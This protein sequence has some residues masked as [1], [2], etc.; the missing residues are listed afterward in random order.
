[1]ISHSDLPLHNTML[2]NDNDNDIFGES[3]HKMSTLPYGL[4]WGGRDLRK[5]GCHTVEG[6]HNA[7]TVRSVPVKRQ[8]STRTFLKRRYTLIL[9]LLVKSTDHNMGS[10]NTCENSF[11]LFNPRMSASS[12]GP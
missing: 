5:N 1:M 9:E 3:L 7:Q 11:F 6:L 2:D 8:V 12:L 10:H 4:E